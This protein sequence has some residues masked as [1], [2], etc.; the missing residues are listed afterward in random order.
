MPA[1]KPAFLTKTAVRFPDQPS[2]R[3]RI[4]PADR[5]LLI[6]PENPVN[7][8]QYRPAKKQAGN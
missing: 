1:K 7:F 6:P 4:R 8:S 3:S 5:P 2:V